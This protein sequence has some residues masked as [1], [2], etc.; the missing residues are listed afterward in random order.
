MGALP[1]ELGYRLMY[2]LIQRRD[3]NTMIYTTPSP[4]CDVTGNK[5]HALK[6]RHQ[7]EFIEGKEDTNLSILF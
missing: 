2:H 5:V 7:Y 3:H 4:P 1:F 6:N